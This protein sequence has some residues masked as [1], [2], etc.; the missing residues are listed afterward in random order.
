MPLPFELSANGAHSP[1]LQ[2]D[3]ASLE[4]AMRMLREQ[5]ERFRRKTLTRQ[6]GALQA[7][8]QRGQASGFGQNSRDL[9]LSQRDVALC[10]RGEQSLLVR[11]IFI[12]RADAHARLSG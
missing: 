8:E 5:R 7:T 9:E 6:D 4:R 12:Q 1:L 2:S 3:R 11:K 10:E